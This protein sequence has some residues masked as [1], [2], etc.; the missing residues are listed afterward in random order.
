MAGRRA[1]TIFQFVVLVGIVAILAGVI[2]IFAGR[3]RHESEI[4]LQRADFQIIA[5]GLE[6][7]KADFGDY[8]RNINL[9]VWN[10]EQDGP[11]PA[12]VFY[13]LAPALLGPGPAVTEPVNGV[14]EIGDGAD[15]YGFRCQ[16]AP[17]IS[18]SAKATIGNRSIVMEIDPKDRDQATK[19][20]AD[21]RPSALLTLAAT[22]TQPYPE[23]IGV[24]TATL[25]GN[26]LQLTLAAG[27]T[28]PHDGKCSIAMPAGKVWGPYISPDRFKVTYVPS[29]DSYGSPFFGYGQPVLLDRWGQVIQYFPR[30]RGQPAPNENWPLFGDCQPRSVDPTNGNSSIFDWRDG[31]PFFTVFGQTGPAQAWPNPAGGAANSFRPELAIEW[32]LRHDIDGPYFLIS[33]GSQGLERPNGGFCNMADPSN[34]N[35]SFPQEKLDQIFADSGNIYN[36]ESH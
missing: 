17:S 19:L 23:T 13:S 24:R 22:T 20:A 16:T 2:F 5:A 7:Y 9:P 15:G 31:A 32:M 1:F 4:D 21:L 35:N 18:G 11:T 3:M 28:Y 14:L 12:P 36:F 27:P 29:V 30:Y 25:S 34:G 10:T 6:A 8:P 26:Q 33:V